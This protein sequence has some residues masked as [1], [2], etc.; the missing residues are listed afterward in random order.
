MLA[1]QGSTMQDVSIYAAPDA[2]AGVYGGNGGGGSFV[3]VTVVGARF[4]FDIRS[5][6]GYATVVASTAINSSCAGVIVGA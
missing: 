2:L 5:S 4:G 3:G 1:A 6:A